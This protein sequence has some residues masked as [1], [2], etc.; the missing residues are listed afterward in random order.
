MIEA[1]L[2]ALQKRS[3]HPHP[4]PPPPPPFQA[5]GECSHDG[6]GK[7][8]FALK[9]AGMALRSGGVGGAQPPPIGKPNAR[10]IGLDRIHMLRSELARFYRRG[11]W[12]GRSPPSTVCKHNARMMALGRIQCFENACT[13]GK[14]GGCRAGGGAGGRGRGWGG[15]CK[16]NDLGDG[17]EGEGALFFLLRVRG[18]V[19]FFCCGCGGAFFFLLRVRGRHAPGHSLTGAA[20]EKSTHSKKAPTPKKRHGFPKKPSGLNPKP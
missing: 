2:P 12:A 19:F 6:F 14:R 15:N 3:P 7:D 17:E 5:G 1:R 11:G 8:S 10:M 4:P 18:R 16:T 20:P 13:V 9:Q